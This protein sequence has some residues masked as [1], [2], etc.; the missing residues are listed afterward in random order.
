MKATF[1]KAQLLAAIAPAAGI[2]QIK[3]TLTTIEGL[4]FECPP[5]PKMGS[6]DGDGSDMCRISAFDLEKGLRTTLPCTI[7]REGK[8]VISGSKILQI[9]RALPDGEITIDIDESLRAVIS[10][11]SGSFE[12]SVSPGEDFPTMPMFKGDRRYTFPQHKVRRMVS[13]TIFAAAQNDQRVALN[14][15]L[16]K[17]ENGNMTVV[18]CD[19]NRMSCTTDIA[20]DDAPDCEIIVPG[21]FLT[22]LLR[23]I[24]DTEDE[25]EM[26]IGLKHIIFKIDSIYFFCR[27]IESKYMDYSRVLPRSFET[28]LYVNASELRG[29]LERAAIISEDKLGGNSKA[30]VKLAVSSDRIDMSAVSTSGSIYETLSAAV[31]GDELTIGFNCRYLLDAIRAVPSSVETLRIGFNGPHKGICIEPACGSTFVELSD[32]R[33]ETE[34]SEQSEKGENFLHFIMPRRL[35]G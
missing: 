28:E 24:R 17:I 9:V 20:P 23:M 34:R 32:A 14:G 3:N 31:T 19:S 5:D 2:S 22:E 26:I 25:C 21:K 11:T 8:Y 16:L 10:G 27:M 29:A 18:A 7:E 12:I 4:L 33:G 15:E 13:E 30:Q 1:D 35:N 6:F